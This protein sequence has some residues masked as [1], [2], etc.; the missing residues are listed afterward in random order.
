M[1]FFIQALLYFQKDSLWKNL[2]V[3]GFGRELGKKT[4]E[5]MGKE[6]TE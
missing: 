1:V 4:M 6:K 5:R 3:L 2:M